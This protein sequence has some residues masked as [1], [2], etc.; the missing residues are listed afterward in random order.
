MFFLWV[1]VRGSPPSPIWGGAP[2]S[3]SGAGGL[4]QKMLGTLGLDLIFVGMMVFQGSPCMGATT[5]IVKKQ[6]PRAGYI[7]AG[8][9]MGAV[10]GF[11]TACVK[12]VQDG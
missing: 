8:G 9:P 4:A 12:C 10:M 6:L 5:W 11:A 7:L 2:F 1:I 3:M